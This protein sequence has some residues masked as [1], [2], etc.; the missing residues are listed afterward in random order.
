MPEGAARA[1][2]A[3]EAPPFRARAPWLGGD[4]QTIRNTLFNRLGL[5]VDLEPWPAERLSL[6]M[7][8]GTG[9]ALMAMLHRPSSGADGP[10]AVLAHGLTGCEDSAYL[11]NSAHSLLRAGFPVLR[12]NLRGAGPSRLACRREYHAGRSE[13]LRAALAR[14]PADAMAGGVVAIGYSLGANMLLKYLGEEG[15]GAGMRAAVAISAPIDLKSAQLRIMAPRNRVYHRY[16]LDRMKIECTEG[17][18]GVS[19]EE[20]A[21]V[22]AADSVYA[23]D[24]VFVARRNGF[25][26]ADGY[27]S[28][29]SAE[30]F[31][32]AIR[33]PTL[34]IH[35]HDDPWIP[36]DAYLRHDWSANPCLTPL[37]PESG[38]HVGFHGRGDRRAW[39][40]RCALAFFKAMAG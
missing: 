4:L 10:L 31:L 25:G 38:G 12:L 24:D 39:H 3:F 8:D 40:D 20:R 14:L 18:D 13:D 27:Y 35:A 23:F 15:A 32:P 7:E 34:V 21:A 16:M 36:V 6:A 1:R 30:R 19:E 2:T 11:R 28:A 26:T 37:L 5:G 22:L 29:C 9:D 17:R 33:V